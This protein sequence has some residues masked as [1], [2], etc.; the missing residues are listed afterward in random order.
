MF[1]MIR[2]EKTGLELARDEALSNLAHLDAFNDPEKYATTLNQ[3]EQLSKLIA[4]EAPA[5]LN[6]N[7]VAL[8]VANVFIAL[9]VVK[10]ED[11]NV[12]TTKVLPFLMKSL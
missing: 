8:V 10:Y 4:E 2:S 5:K 3:I 7:T 9:K 12:V 6:V 1:N 11:T